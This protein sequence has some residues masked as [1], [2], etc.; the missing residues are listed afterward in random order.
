MILFLSDSFEVNGMD[1]GQDINGISS[2]SCIRFLDIS[3]YSCLFPPCIDHDIFEGIFPKIVKFALTYF[4]SNRYM[5][6]ASNFRVRGII[7][8]SGIFSGNLCI[9]IGDE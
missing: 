1:T 2:Q 3:D 8:S 4:I 5:T 7:S 6:R 9:N